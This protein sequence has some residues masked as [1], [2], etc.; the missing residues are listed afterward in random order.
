MVTGRSLELFVLAALPLALFPG[1]SV[2]FI[3]TSSLRHGTS[4]GVR[5]TAGVEVGYLV[6]V[7]AAVVG[8]SALLA[9]STVAFSMV[10]IAGALYLI[11]LAISAWRDSRSASDDPVV[12]I[13]DSPE[14]AGRRKPFRQGLLV[15]SSNPKTAIFF[16]AFLP[17]FANPSHGPIAPQLLILGLVFILLA[18][19]PD[20]SWAVA[21][22]KL[23][24]R[25]GRLR[26]KIADRVAAVVY[27]GLA[28]VVLSV[29]RASS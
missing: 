22:G 5:A 18:C 10:K 8:V 11:W 19:L 29:N 1:P 4:Y 7:F 20:F 17:Q 13:D 25:L 26:R 2:A 27:A 15:G 14:V 9:A 23:R 24:R 28:A 21:A 3:V 12:S 16:L 6:H